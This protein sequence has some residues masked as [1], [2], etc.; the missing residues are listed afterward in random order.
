MKRTRQL[1]QD[2]FTSLIKE[3]DFE[4]I[5]VRD[6]TTKATVNRATFYAHFAD[7]YEILESKINET[8]MAIVTRRVSDHTVLNDETLES[9]F[10]AVCDFHK[11]LSTLCR[12]SYTSLG[13]VFETQIKEKIQAI[14][15]SL[16][17]KDEPNSDPSE[18]LFRNTAATLL[19]WG[20]Y[21]AAYAWNREGRQVS[22]ES[23]VKQAMPFV[24]DG[25]KAL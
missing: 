9:I 11:G 18:T 5:T 17:K 12:R 24:T 8:F 22:A 10:L 3:K 23:F 7:K 14:L 16:M 13:P 15:L 25:V 4:S 2:A 21:G 1:L 20:M 19:S 6:I